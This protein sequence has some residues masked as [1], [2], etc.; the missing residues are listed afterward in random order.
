M[1]V[2]TI[3]LP[4]ATGV[5]RIPRVKLWFAGKS[6]LH[7]VRVKEFVILRCIH[8]AT[9]PRPGDPYREP[10]DVLIYESVPII[11][12]ICK[13]FSADLSS[14]CSCR[15]VTGTTSEYVIR[16]VAALRVSL[17]WLQHQGKQSQERSHHIN[18]QPAGC[19]PSQ[20]CQHPLLLLL[21]LR[22]TH[23]SRTV[24]S[25]LKRKQGLETCL[26]SHKPHSQDTGC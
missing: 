13:G 10:W 20:H 16:R 2:I 6:Q 14:K 17:S 24:S 23:S 22:K 26:L 1:A 25:S 8:H 9:I 21:L 7:L 12:S 3:S 5:P 19:G 15:P 4:N 11:S 18:T